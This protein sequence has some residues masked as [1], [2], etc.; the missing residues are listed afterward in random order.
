MKNWSLRKKILSL[1]LSGIVVIILS[2][3]IILYSVESEIIFNKKDIYNGA[4][5]NI[6]N[7]INDQFYERYGDVQTFSLSFSNRNQTRQEGEKFLNKFASL[8]GI[9]NLIMV[10]DLK[11]NLI[12]VNSQDAS[13]KKINSEQFY[14]QNFSKES[15]FT[16]VIEKNFLEDKSKGFENVY[17]EDP[18]FDELVKKASGEDASYGTIFATFVKNDKGENIGVIA[19]HA[20]FIWVEQIF[21]R[22]YE[23]DKTQYGYH[24]VEFALLDKK[25][26][27]ILD[28]KPLL[29]ET[30]NIIRDESVLG[31]LNLSEKVSKIKEDLR[32]KIEGTVESR[33]S[34]TNEIQF[35]NFQYINGNKIID[36][37]G[38]SILV[39]M[40]KNELLASV[41]KTILTMTVIFAIVIALVSA[42]SVLFAN[43]LS[44]K[45]NAIAKQLF[46]GSKELLITSSNGSKQSQNLSASASEQA[47]ALQETV[48][49]V[50]EI[51]SMLFKTAEMSSQSQL[52]AEK[53]TASVE[54]GKS[55]IENLMFSIQNIKKSNEDIFNQVED[56]N[57][58]IS[59]IVQ[60]IGD[61]ENKTKVINEIV[62]QTKLLSF[63]ASVEAARAGEHG[64]G[65]AVVAEEVGNLAQMSGAASKEISA[66][67]EE[68]TQKVKSI[69]G[70][71]S[72]KVSVLIKN[73]TNKIQEGETVGQKCAENFEEIYKHTTEINSNINEIKASTKEQSKGVQ[74]I[75]QAM[76]ELDSVTQSNSH[77]A[78]ETSQSSKNLLKQT[79]MIESVT[80]SLIDFI[81]GKQTGDVKSMNH[82]PTKN[83]TNYNSTSKTNYSEKKS[84]K[85]EIKPERKHLVSASSDKQKQTMNSS[86]EVEHSPHQEI[87]SANDARFEDL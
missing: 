33:N 82:D 80:H 36:S 75:T 40:D 50:T 84:E 45:L 14:G 68:S 17:F 22:E 19:T 62:F 24:K 83:K 39:R 37:L 79:Q 85:F 58:K 21:N 7:G 69:V 26:N 5:D 65:F 60:L 30:K 46:N 3:V 35:V 18:H 44:Q 54:E 16:G 49:A 20:D 34:K 53:S 63:N 38:W 86:K 66:M 28:Y 12:A 1:S 43:S 27:V 8:Y 25:S 64:K 41:Y 77:I 13:G 15:W 76:H 32:G 73:A 29:Q 47:A 48:A 78:N 23:S 72:M 42:M 71:I 74:E 70:D 51:S 10:T 87:P 81:D 55:A 11:G 61:I 4:I 31:K 52:T 67:L 56:G 57:R 6:T 2:V 9:Y 59:N